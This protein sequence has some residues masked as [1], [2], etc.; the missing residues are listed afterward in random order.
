MRHF[1]ACAN[2]QTQM[3][4]LS[5]KREVL[6]AGLDSGLDW[7]LDSALDSNAGKVL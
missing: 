4:K 1:H 6:F 7:T 2:V 3:Q 5:W